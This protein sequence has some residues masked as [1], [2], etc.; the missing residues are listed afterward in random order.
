MSRNRMVSFDLPKVF[1]IIFQQ[2][3]HNGQKVP[4]L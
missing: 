3:I 2:A 4:I 1:E